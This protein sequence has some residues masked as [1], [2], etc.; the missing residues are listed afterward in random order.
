GIPPPAKTP[1]GSGPQ[2]R[3]WDAPASARQPP[4]AAMLPTAP[5]S[6]AP[7]PARPDRDSGRLRPDRRSQPWARLE[8]PQRDLRHPWRFRT[9]SS[10]YRASAWHRD[11]PA[12]AFY[13]V[14]PALPRAAPSF[15]VPPVHGRG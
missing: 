3:T 1:A 7:S 5:L 9:Y 2:R 8:S 10:G 4:T 12:R 14:P 13:S 15:E 6:G 11:R